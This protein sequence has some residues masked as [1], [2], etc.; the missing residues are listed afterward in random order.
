LERR[1]QRVSGKSIMGVMML[2]A[3]QGSLVTLSVEGNDEDSACA[4][5]VKLI[6]NRFGEDE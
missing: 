3:S 5:I 4:A 2:A 6:A 1:G